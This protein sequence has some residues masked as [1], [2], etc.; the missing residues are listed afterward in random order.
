MAKGRRKSKNN[1]KRRARRFNPRR[2]VLLVA[3][4]VAVWQLLV[5]GRAAVVTTFARTATVESGAVQVTVRVDTWPLPGFVPERDT[6]ITPI[7]GI[8]RLLVP[9]GSRVRAGEVVA[10]IINPDAQGQ[11]LDELKRTQAELAAFRRDNSGEVERLRGEISA[12][13]RQ[14]QQ[15]MSELTQ[16]IRAGEQSKALSLQKTIVSLTTDK[17]RLEEQANAL[18]EREQKLIAAE[19]VAQQAVSRSAL[20]LLA[21]RPGVV[22]YRFDGLEETLRPEAVIAMGSKALLGLRPR[23]FSLSDG[24]RVEAGQRVF[25]LYDTSTVDLVLVANAD[26]LLQEFVLGATVK[27]TWAEAGAA[28]TGWVDEVGPVERNGYQV[29][30]VKTREYTAKFLERG[31]WEA[32]VVQATYRGLVIPRRALCERQGHTGVYLVAKGKTLFAPV[33]VVGGNADAVV[34]EGIAAGDQVITNPWLVG[35]DGIRIR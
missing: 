4:A 10:E 14:I 27:L 32:A 28:V 25:K 3:L 33:T 7:D 16:A 8:V 26:R 24:A 19:Q 17:V 35:R 22:S 12:L 6:T 29:V 5:W 2:L 15:K 21:G 34:V 23:P 18:Q 13:D 31:P 20:Q 11:L 1:Q 9:E 30:R